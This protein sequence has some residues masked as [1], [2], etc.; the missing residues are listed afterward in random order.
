LEN[1]KKV[2]LLQSQNG[3]NEAKRETKKRE[4]LERKEMI[5]ET[6]KPR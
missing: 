5:F 4:P 2:V 1:K 6:K 3:Q